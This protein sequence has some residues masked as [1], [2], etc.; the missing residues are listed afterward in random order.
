MEITFVVVS[1]GIWYEPLQKEIAV[2]VD[3][4]LQIFRV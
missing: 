4:D 3:L 1:W 2:W